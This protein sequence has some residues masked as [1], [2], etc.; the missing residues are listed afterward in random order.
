LSGA[1]RRAGDALARRACR[2]ALLFYAKGGYAGGAANITISLPSAGA[3]ASQSPHLNGW[4]AG[5]GIEYK[6]LQNLSLGVEYDHYDMSYN[7]FGAANPASYTQFGG[8]V[9]I[10]AVMVRAN[11]ESDWLSM[12]FR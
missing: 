8:R 3:A 10:D 2:A 12:L 5:A 6:M 4:T 1:A 11:I 9:T 7:P